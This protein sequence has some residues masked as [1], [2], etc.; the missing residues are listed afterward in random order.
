[1]GSVAETGREPD[2]IRGFLDPDAY[3]HPVDRVRIIETHISWVVLTGEFAYKI[4][5]PVKFGFVDFSTLERRRFYCEEEL[6]LNRRTAPDLYLDVVPVALTARGIRV[7]LEPA[8]EYAVRM[9]QFA[10]QARLDVRLAEGRLE[11]AD[12][13]GAASEIARFHLG[14]PPWKFADEAGAGKRCPQPALNNF[15]HM[16]Q[17][18]LPAA[19]RELTADL[20]DWTRQRSDSLGPVFEARARAGIIRE[21]HGD[22]HLANLFEQGGRIVPYDCLEFSPDLRCI[23]PVSDISFLVMDLMAHG[24]CDL[25]FA[26]LN[27]WLEETGD[28]AG[29]AVLRFYL[30][31]RAMVLVKVA[32]LHA[33]QAFRGERSEPGLDASRYLGLARSLAYQEHRPVLVLMHGLSGSGKTWL[34][35]RLLEAAPII[36]VRSDLERKR[37]PGAAMAPGGASPAR[38]DLY[39]EEATASTY[40]LLARHC[41][42]GLREGFHMVADASFLNRAHRLAFIR[43]AERA[44]AAPVILHCEASRSALWQRLRDRRAAGADASDADA[45]VVRQQ[46]VR[47]HALGAGEQGLVVS[48]NTEMPLDMPAL[49]RAVGIGPLQQAA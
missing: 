20:R 11:P 42:T 18:V 15:I 35:E 36:R 3:P 4:K 8:V 34:S 27:R 21:C 14:L 16:E 28:Y 17:D 23:D 38:T 32:T 30:V 12:M 33:G 6:R 44:G 49:L 26:F 1:M 46:L 40:A 10:R 22:L 37:L 45:G 24:R 25:A 13:R 9:R 2:W 7:G 41:E 19:A 39:G 48:V 43:M 31:Y 29:I 47:Q 5:K